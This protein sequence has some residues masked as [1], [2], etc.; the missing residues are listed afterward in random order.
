MKKRDAIAQIG[1][2]QEHTM[3]MNARLEELMN[4]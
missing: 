3:T 4:A 1:V 2:L